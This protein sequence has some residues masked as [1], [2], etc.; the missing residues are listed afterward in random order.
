VKKKLTLSQTDK[1]IFGVCGGMAEYLEVD[2]TFIRIMWVAASLVWGAGIL[3]YI[4]C[5]II[6]PK[7][8]N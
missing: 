8:E 3:I 6:I 4:L 2:S 5:A 7:K 1:K